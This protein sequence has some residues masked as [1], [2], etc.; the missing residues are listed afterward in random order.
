MLVEELAT[1]NLSKYGGTSSVARQAAMEKKRR[2]RPGGKD[3]FGGI[4]SLHKELIEDQKKLLS[5]EELEKGKTRLGLVQLFC[6]IPFV[7]VLLNQPMLRTYR[8]LAKKDEGLNIDFTGNIVKNIERI[9]PYTGKRESKPRLIA[10]L[11][12]PNFLAWDPLRLKNDNCPPIILWKMISDSENGFNLLQGL[13]LIMHLEQDTFDSSTRLRRIWSDC[14][15]VILNVV[16]Q[17]FNMETKEKYFKRLLRR[18]FLE[19]AP[20]E[21]KTLVNWCSPMRWQ[22]LQGGRNTTCRLLTTTE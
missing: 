7:V 8:D 2:E 14:A 17:V 11:S 6:V 21:D 5:D 20:P 1:G 16:L 9:N 4:I 10:T 19:Q 22:R 15:E 18:A 3:D 12:A 13:Q